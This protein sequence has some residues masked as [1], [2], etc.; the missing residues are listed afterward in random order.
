MKTLK[1]FCMSILLTSAALSLQ[2]TRAQ[3][4]P[5]GTAFGIYY[6][7]WTDPK[8]LYRLLD[9][10]RYEQANGLL[11][12]WGYEKVDFLRLLRNDWV[13]TR[14]SLQDVN[15]SSV[16]VIMQSKDG[17]RETVRLHILHPR[18]YFYKAITNRSAPNQL[19]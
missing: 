14:I 6:G 19:K 16:D 12:D 5:L 11:N 9:I 2:Q 8:D 7:D 1:F 13:P 4:L 15:G 10:I 17:I 3:E 18:S